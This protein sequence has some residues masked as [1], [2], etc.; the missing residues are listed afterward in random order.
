MTVSRYLYVRCRCESE[1]SCLGTQ[2]T[3]RLELETFGK[4]AHRVFL[5][6]TLEVFLKLTHNHRVFYLTPHSISHIFFHSKYFEQFNFKTV[7]KWL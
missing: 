4:I 7:L 3:L 5:S 6:T 2:H 1:I